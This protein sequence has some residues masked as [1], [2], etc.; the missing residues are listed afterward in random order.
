MSVSPNL[1]KFENLK[2]DPEA[3]TILKI[4]VANGELSISQLIKKYFFLVEGATS[5][6]AASEVVFPKV[7]ILT[8]LISDSRKKVRKNSNLSFS[9]RK[10]ECFRTGKII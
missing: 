8:K 9:S 10:Y 7:N 6:E 5:L 1:D 2:Q 4:L 3:I